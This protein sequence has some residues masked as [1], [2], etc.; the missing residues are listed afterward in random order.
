[1]R[2]TGVEVNAVVESLPHT[3]GEA[4]LDLPV[5]KPC[6]SRLL[7]GNDAVVVRQYC[8]DALD[9]HTVVD[10]SATKRFRLSVI[11]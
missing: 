2:P 7:E 5:A 8:G 11:M 6:S 1:M 10:A 9:T 3:G 4:F